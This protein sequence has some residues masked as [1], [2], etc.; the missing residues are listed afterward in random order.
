VGD[1]PKVLTMSKE[2]FE[3]LKFKLEEAQ[4]V[5]SQKQIELQYAKQRAI[6]HQQELQDQVT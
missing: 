1:E 2:E 3:L 6:V 5:I 4:R